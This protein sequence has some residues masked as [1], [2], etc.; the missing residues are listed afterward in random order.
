[1]I[2]ILKNLFVGCVSDT[3]KWRDRWLLATTISRISTWR[4]SPPPTSHFDYLS[5]H[6][7]FPTFGR[8]SRLYSHGKATVRV[9]RV[10]MTIGYSERKQKNTQHKRVRNLLSFE[11]GVHITIRC[12]RSQEQ[13]RWDRRCI[14]RLERQT[15][16][17]VVVYNGK[18]RLRNT[19]VVAYTHST[20]DTSESAGKYFSSPVWFVMGAQLQQ[21]QHQRAKGGG[22]KEGARGELSTLIKEETRSKV[23]TSLFFMA[24]LSL[25]LVPFLSLFPFIYFSI[26]SCCCCELL[27]SVEEREQQQKQEKRGAKREKGWQPSNRPT[28]ATSHL[29]SLRRREGEPEVDGPLFLSHVTFETRRKRST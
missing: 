23:W 2:S 29:F 4:P 8:L 5:S 26:L 13:Q 21:Q 14:N 6:S 25:F 12:V 7:P 15:Y 3:R 17:R 18:N 28:A 22:R 20:T 9:D 10:D 27:G 19:H 24:L 1:M 11:L 16:T